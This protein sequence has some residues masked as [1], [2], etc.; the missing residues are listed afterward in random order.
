[1]PIHVIG[2]A[3]HSAYR[4][5]TRTGTAN[6]SVFIGVTAASAQQISRE[7]RSRR[8]RGATAKLKTQRSGRIRAGRRT[9]R[10][11]FAQ[12]RNSMPLSPP[13]ASSGASFRFHPA[14][15][16]PA[17]NADRHEGCHP[18]VSQFLYPVKLTLQSVMANMRWTPSIGGI[19]C[20]KIPAS[21]RAIAREGQAPPWCQCTYRQAIR[22]SAQT[23]MLFLN[24][25]IF[26]T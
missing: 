1:M 20:K 5:S 17:E 19:R 8:C 26:Q 14:T 7:R 10:S 3:V 15:Q 11:S 22:I 4:L 21:D 16:P 13:R 23:K 6:G 24:A 9:R 25:Y 2:P 12:C 18:N